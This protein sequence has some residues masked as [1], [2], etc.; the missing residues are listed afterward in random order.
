MSYIIEMVETQEQPTLVLRTVT[1]VGEL[2][3]ILG[4]AFMDIVTHIMELGE[5]PVGP[6]FVGYF[7]MDME[8]LELEIGFPVSK[9]LPGKGDIQP[10]HIPAGKQVACMYKGPYMEMP[11]AYEEIQ[12]WIKDQGYKPL[13]PV[14]EHY[15]NSPEEVPESELLTKIVFLVE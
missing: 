2:P 10:G 15:Y 7:N 1:Y 13:G 11:P 3:K 8:R 5:Q 12:K 4:K 9:E 14:Y 6:A